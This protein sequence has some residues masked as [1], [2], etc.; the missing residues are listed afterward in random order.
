MNILKSK[1]RKQLFGM[2]EKQW[3]ACPEILLDKVFIKTGKQRI[4][5]VNRDIDRIDMEG[6]RINTIG[7]YIAEYKNELRLNIEGAQL[8][9]PHAT[10]NIHELSDEERKQWFMGEDLTITK[11]YE[12]FIIL[13]HG[14]DY[15][16]SGK[17]KE[18]KIINY[19]PKSRR[20]QETH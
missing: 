3:G 1:E 17:Y 5:M 7:L 16:G 19:M 9:G 4:Y 2:I 6:I 12:G 14:K 13:K 11:S 20:L 10:K 8:I 15:I 18:G